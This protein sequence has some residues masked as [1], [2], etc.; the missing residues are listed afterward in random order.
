ME[1][2][3]LRYYLTVV[4][5]ENITRA[6]EILHITQPTLSRQLTE[7]EAELGT[8]LFVRGKR[9]ISL[10]DSGML[11]RR[12]AEELIELADKTAS[13]FS[14]YGENLSGSVAIGAG[15]TTATKA[16]PEL[17]RRFTAQYPLVHFELHTGNAKLLTER[18]DSG[19]LDIGLL[20]EPVE[21]EKY[22]F[23]RLPVKEVWGVIVPNDH[24]LGEKAVVTPADLRPLPLIATPRIKEHETRAWFGGDIEHLNI[25]ATCDMAGNAAALVEQGLGVAFT[26]EGA[27]ANYNN[28]VFRPLQPAVTATSV[29]VWKKYQPFS[30]AVREFV[31]LIKQTY[32]E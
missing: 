8:Q 3:V 23:V 24:P 1:L 16:L 30:P 5:E 27:V 6:A 28:V 4:R 15:E 29:L 20:M 13:E 12:R 14:G 18:L 9:K 21:I 19:L 7:L 22:D 26:I 2:R 32:R 31:Q 10:T 17:M 11:L 25:C